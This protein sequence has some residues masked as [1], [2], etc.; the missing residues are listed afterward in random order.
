MTT[1]KEKIKVMQAYVDGAEIGCKYENMTE[2]FI[3]GRG[4]DP[5][6]D[7]YKFEF[8]IK[9]KSGKER[10]VEDLD[11]LPLSIESLRAVAM[12]SG[13]SGLSIAGYGSQWQK[14]LHKVRSGEYDDWEGE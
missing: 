10:L 6:W 4:R 12:S 7:W 1:T 8:F 3:K 14:I 11:A 2:Y 5:I 13:S 9:R